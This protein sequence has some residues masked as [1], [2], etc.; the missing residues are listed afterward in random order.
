MCNSPRKRKDKTQGKEKLKIGSWNM[1]IAATQPHAANV[2]LTSQT[3]EDENLDVLGICECNIFP[4]THLEGLKIK[5]YSLEIGEGVNRPTDGNARV[6]MYVS[7]N[8]QYTR[9]RDLEERSSMPQ[10][11]VEM[12][13]PGTRKLVLGTV[14]RQFKEWRGVEEEYK[15]GNQHAKWKEW[16]ES[17]QDVW[18]GR[19]MWRPP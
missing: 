6:A 11:W 13:L 12:N 4:S 9:R 16:L 14:Y 2:N 19:G 1:A 7:E 15:M 17:L 18:C 8:V 10:V 3:L 5:G